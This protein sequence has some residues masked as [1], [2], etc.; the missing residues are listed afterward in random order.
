MMFKPD[1]DIL[2]LNY[3]E[4]EFTFSVFSNDSDYG[5]AHFTSRPLPG[6]PEHF[7]SMSTENLSFLME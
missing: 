2:E 3:G 5:L 6:S 1:S 4:K 7:W